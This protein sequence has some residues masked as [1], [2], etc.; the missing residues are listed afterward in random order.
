MD[1]YNLFQSIHNYFSLKLMWRREISLY[2]SNFRCLIS[3]QYKFKI[4]YT[5][6][7][8]DA[9][10]HEDHPLKI[11]FCTACFVNN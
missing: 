6:S 9:I 8:T 4:F 10:T 3:Y 2:L 11:K 7:L 5:I 1:S